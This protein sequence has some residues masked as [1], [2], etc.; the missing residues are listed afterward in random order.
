[1]AETQT[2][3]PVSNG[4]PLIVRAIREFGPMTV[5]AFMLVGAMF[6]WIPSPMADHIEQ[7][8]LVHQ[9]IAGLQYATCLNTAR[10]NQEVQ[11]CEH[12]APFASQPP[13]P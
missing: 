12:Y 13:L 11:R 8:S 9:R 1:M 3:A 4:S 10:T 6:G 7:M 2:P 5:L